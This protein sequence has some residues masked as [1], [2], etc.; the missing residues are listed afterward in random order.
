MKLLSTDDFVKHYERLPASIRKKG[1]E[2]LKVLLSNP[3]HSSL[4]IKKMK[5]YEEI[6][7]GRISRSYRF[8]FQIKEDTYIL[9][10]VGKHEV[11]EKP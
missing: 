5:G 6:W 4:Q 11:L 2:K 10:K 1:D 3:R 7:E 8:T 9:R